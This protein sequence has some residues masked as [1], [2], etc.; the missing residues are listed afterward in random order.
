MTK[1]SG[2]VCSAIGEQDA[3]RPDPSSN[4]DLI[5]SSLS[6]QCPSTWDDLPGLTG[7]AS[8]HQDEQQRRESKAYGAEQHDEVARS[9]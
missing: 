8:K 6:G 3:G 9:R 4:P 5:A 1:P 2:I 7:S